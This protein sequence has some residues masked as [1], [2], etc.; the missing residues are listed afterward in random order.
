MFGPNNRGGNFADITG[1]L[2]SGDTNIGD[3]ED[4]EQMESGWI[5]EG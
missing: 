1:G 2:F 5:L 4:Q 3:V